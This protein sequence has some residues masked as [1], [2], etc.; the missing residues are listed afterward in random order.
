MDYYTSNETAAVRE[1]YRVAP[2]GSD[3]LAEVGYLPWRYQDYEWSRADP[4]RG[5]HRYLSLAQEWELEPNKSARD[6]VVWTA[7]TLRSSPTTR[8]PAGFLILS[9]S[10]RAHEEILGGLS[11]SLMDDYERILVRSGKF[12]LAYANQDAKIYARIAGK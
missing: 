5:G 3:L 2:P 10:Q 7:E 11:P 8:R 9:R 6:M 4:A 12:R 1:L